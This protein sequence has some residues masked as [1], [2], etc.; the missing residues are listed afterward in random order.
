[1]KHL[2]SIIGTK[3]KTV[4]QAAQ[5]MFQAHQKFQEIHKQ[6]LADSQDQQKKS[7]E[8]PKPTEQSDQWEVTLIPT[9]EPGQSVPRQSLTPPMP[10]QRAKES[11]DGV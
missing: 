4:E 3:G 10:E 11:I 9:W 7:V 6:S 2:V 8:S 1:M 5:E